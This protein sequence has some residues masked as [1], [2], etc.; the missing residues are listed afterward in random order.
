MPKNADNSKIKVA[1]VLQSIFSET[2]N[3]FVPNLKFLAKS[4]WAFDRGVNNSV[5]KTS[6]KILVIVGSVSVELTLIIGDPNNYDRWWKGGE[7]DLKSL[8][9]G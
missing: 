6:R 8:T 3:V 1:L 2:A 4:Y 5:L 9:F 7:V